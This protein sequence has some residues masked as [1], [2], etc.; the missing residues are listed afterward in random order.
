MFMHPSS[1]RLHLVAAGVFLL[2]I[3]APA[4]GQAELSPL[5]WAAFF[6]SRKEY[7]K[8]INE[9]SKAIAEQPD[10]TSLYVRRAE[11]YAELPD[12]AAM[13]ADARHALSLNPYEFLPD[14]NNAAE[15]VMR[16]LY[17]NRRFEE[18][19]EIGDELIRQG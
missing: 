17:T 14:G 15:K 18:G 13:V 5:E 11:L 4:F 7:A 3:A 6:E 19:I 8:A 1:L 10:S 12:G 2:A 9:I 16:L